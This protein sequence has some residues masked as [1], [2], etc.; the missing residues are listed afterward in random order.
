MFDYA[1]KEEND[2]SFKAGDRIEV[3][4]RGDGPNDWWVGRLRGVVGEFPGQ[5]TNE[6][7]IK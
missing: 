7:K 1:G 5:M 2:L 3:L 6:Y 4:E